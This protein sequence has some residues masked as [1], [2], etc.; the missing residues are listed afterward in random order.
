[1]AHEDHEHLAALLRIPYREL[2]RTLYERLGKQGFDDLQPAHSQV[3]PYLRGGP[4]Q[5][6]VLAERAQIT[7]Q[8]MSYLLGS[9]EER[10]YVSR[11]T[12][13]QDG[14][15]KVVELTDRGREAERA[16]TKIIDSIEDE[17]SDVLGADSAADLR[18]LLEQLLAAVRARRNATG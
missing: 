11:S 5:S 17:W 15:A 14:R 10:G 18:R 4:S 3:F 9:L 6:A 2:V 16:A 12:S 1:M 8:S 13:A 7:K